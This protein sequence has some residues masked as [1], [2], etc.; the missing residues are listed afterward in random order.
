MI[1]A[2]ALF[3][4]GWAY[5]ERGD[6]PYAQWFHIFELEAFISGALVLLAILVMIW[7]LYP[8][9]KKRAIYEI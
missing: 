1:D 5:I 7:F 6:L 8:V 4:L 2:I 3:V 9:E